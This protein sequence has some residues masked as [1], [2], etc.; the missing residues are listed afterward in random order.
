MARHDPELTKAYDANRRAIALSLVPETAV[1]NFEAMPVHERRYRFDM[2]EAE[3][4]RNDLLANRPGHPSNDYHRLVADNARKT[5]AA[6]KA[7]GL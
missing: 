3:A 7:I 4:R 6:L 2:A 1:R 5:A